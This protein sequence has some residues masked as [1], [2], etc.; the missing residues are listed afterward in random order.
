[1][2]APVSAEEI[3]P[4]TG[5]I[6]ADG[7]ELVKKTCIRCHSAKN[8]TQYSG[9]RLT[10]LGMI[11]WMQ[12]TQGLEKFDADTEKQILDYLETNYGPKE[13]NY[14][15]AH[16]PSFLMPPNPYR[17]LATIKFVGLKDHYKLDDTL[18]VD[19][20]IADFPV[21]SKGRFDLWAAIHLPN[22]PDDEFVFLKGTASEPLFSSLKP[23][24]FQVS[25]ET[26][27]STYSVLKNFRLPAVETGEYV[28]YAIL[29]EKNANPL[30][31]TDITRSNLAVQIITVGD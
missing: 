29:A 10:W 18:T 23:Q 20:V 9:T 16:I 21:Y 11:S 31:G 2:V 4:E 28:F 30:T 7:Y 3:D 27:N 1:M 8:I 26:V 14:R 12:T 19:L 5:L 24:S 6:I 17:S 25:L 15:R 22:K 13:A